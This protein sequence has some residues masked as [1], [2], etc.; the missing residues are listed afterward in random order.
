MNSPSRSHTFTLI[1]A[2]LLS[3]VGHATG[4][5]EAATRRVTRPGAQVQINQIETS[6]FPKVG[7]DTL[8]F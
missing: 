5:D 6:Q 1:G 3:F 8:L 2:A 7:V 4:Q